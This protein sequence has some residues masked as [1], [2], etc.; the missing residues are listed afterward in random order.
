MAKKSSP[1]KRSKGIKPDVFALSRAIVSALLLVL[2][3]TVGAAPFVAVLILI[4]A[5]L[6]SGFDLIFAAI[7]NALRKK[8]YFSSQ[9]LIVICAIASFCAGCYIESV[10]MLAVYQLSSAFLTFAVKKTRSGLYNAVPESYGEEHTRLKSILNSPA[11]SFNSAKDKCMP[12]FDLFSK[13]ALIVGIL[14]AVA[15][16]LLT[17][18]TY[19]M[20]I[21][22][23]CMLIVAAVPASALAALPLYSLAGLSHSAEYGVF[24]KN[25]KTLESIGS[26][27]AVAY[28]KNGV[29]TE[30]EPKLV[31]IN[32][33][34][35]EN[36]DFLRLAAYAAC[37]SSQTFSAPIV[38]AYSGD[39]VS[40][41]ITNF[42]DIYGCGMEAVLRG[43]RHL[44]LG[45]AELFEAR[46]I[47]IPE[48]EQ[49]NGYVLYMAIE[50]SYAGSL[51]LKENVNP[52]A[53]SVISDLA[54]IGGVKSIMLSDDGEEVSEKLARSLGIDELH[55]ECKPSEKADIIQDCKTQHGDDNILM[56]VSAQEREAHT[57]ADIDAMVGD[58]FG[59][60]DVLMSSIGLFG[61]PVAYTTARK[62]KRLSRENIIFTAIIKLVLI[63]LALTG[64]ATL[65]FIILTD[66]AASIIGVLNTL[67][68]SSETQ[69][70]E[71]AE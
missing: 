50:H 52:Y 23:G 38:S 37:N 29:F 2:A 28:D 27:S 43:G 42:Q 21:R 71:N 33:P 68:M 67:R 48:G 45:T 8:N 31:S 46:G 4:L 56:Y 62:L 13:A 54:E 25:A 30:G 26:V 57:A 44:L 65:W 66:F 69:K 10:V 1:K 64:N 19:V 9:C 34:V 61:L 70:E 47:S 51:T 36:E 32:S 59:G 20:S 60:A 15:V 3:Y 12:Y 14:F 7:D 41:Y 17:D 49:K 58:S 40:D 35:L 24:I 53:E 39:I 6:I 5:A 22:R 16:P 63:V 18:M 55:C 11:A